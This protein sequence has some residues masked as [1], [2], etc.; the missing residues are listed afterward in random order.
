M[1]LEIPARPEEGPSDRDL[2]ARA[3]SGDGGAF[4]EVVT[5]HWAQVARIAGRFFRRPEAVEDVCQEVF[6]KAWGALP[7]WK[8]EVPLAHWLSRIAVNACYDELRRKRPEGSLEAMAEGSPHALD[9]L[10]A[11]ESP[12][13]AEAARVT[14]AQLLARL[15]PAER[16][17]LTLTVLEEL[18]VKEV[19]RLT[20]WSQ[21]NVKVRAFRA[22]ARLR[23]SLA[24]DAAR[25]SQ[26]TRH[27][28]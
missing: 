4:E 10:L 20:G 16:L 8:G 17:V 23:K 21:T 11:G 6:V 9:R 3:L 18:P 2:V 26:E 12:E 24:A 27:A 1:S 19:A 28:R 7:K 5:A 14:A 22:R 25:A 13:D 15:A